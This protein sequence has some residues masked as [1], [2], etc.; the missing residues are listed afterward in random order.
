LAFA[1]DGLLFGASDF[2]TCAAIFAT[3]A[4]PALALMASAPALGAPAGL[5]RVWM[6]LAA[7]MG[8]R[9]LLGAARLASADGPWAL[10]AAKPEAGGEEKRVSWLGCVRKNLGGDKGRSQE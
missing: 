1:I 7:F 6:G 5:R 4:M 3:A 9:A 2:R 8:T 10:L